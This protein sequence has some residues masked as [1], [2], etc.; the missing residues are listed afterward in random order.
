ME[1]PDLPAIDPQ[2]LRLDDMGL[3]TRA[4]RILRQL[5]METAADIIRMDSH[6]LMDVPG[7]G[8]GTM[9][10]IRNRL[11]YFGLSLTPVPL[12]ESE[13]KRARRERAEAYKQRW[14]SGETLDQ[15][16]KSEGISRERVRQLISSVTPYDQWISTGRVARQQRRHG[17]RT[18]S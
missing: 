9:H 14:V 16:G 4:H 2:T 6:Q 1:D 18:L 8:E 11:A 10:H 3:N 13:A 17:R 7:L 15:I 12:V 5:S